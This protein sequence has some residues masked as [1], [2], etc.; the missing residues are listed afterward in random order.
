MTG[1]RKKALFDKNLTVLAIHPLEQ[2]TVH[3][4][5]WDPMFAINMTQ[6]SM[7]KLAEFSPR[8]IG[9]IAGAT[10]REQLRALRIGND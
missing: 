10:I 6:Y 7:Q 9:R 3:G 5:G 1:L 8:A 4:T 2:V